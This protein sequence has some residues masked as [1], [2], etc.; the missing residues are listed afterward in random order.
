M[1]S[2]RKKKKKDYDEIPLDDIT[3]AIIESPFQR[4]PLEVSTRIFSHLTDS[5][6]DL[7]LLHLKSVSKSWKQF[8][9]LLILESVSRYLRHRRLKKRLFVEVKSHNYKRFDVIT[10]FDFEYQLKEQSY[11]TDFNDYDMLIYWITKHKGKLSSDLAG[12]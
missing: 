9:D 4:L 8:V 10:E 11:A 6:S 2:I 3:P 1:L 12:T 7:E 5:I